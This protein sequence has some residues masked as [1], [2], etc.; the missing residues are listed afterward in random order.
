MSKALRIECLGCR[1]FIEC[2]GKYDAASCACFS[3]ESGVGLRGYGK[4]FVLIINDIDKFALWEGEI[5]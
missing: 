3:E 4:S 2:T 1:W 5:L